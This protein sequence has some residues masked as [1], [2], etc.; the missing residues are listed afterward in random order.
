M[1]NPY[2]L[3]FAPRGPV[4]TLG[5]KSRPYR[6]TEGHVDKIG[7]YDAFRRESQLGF[8]SDLDISVLDSF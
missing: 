3:D 6:A 5:P 8:Y 2:L 1:R 4:N 7:D